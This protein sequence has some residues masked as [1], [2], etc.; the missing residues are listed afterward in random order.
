MVR[1]LLYEAA[2][3]MLT[4]GAQGPS[5]EGRSLEG[6]SLEGLGAARIRKRSGHKKACVALAQAGGDPAA[7]ADHRRAVPLAG[8]EG[9]REGVNERVRRRQRFR[10]ERK[11]GPRRDRGLGDPAYLVARRT[12]VRDCALYLGRPKPKGTIMKRAGKPAGHDFARQPCSR[13][14]TMGSGVLDRETGIRQPRMRPDGT[15]VTLAAPTR[16]STPEPPLQRRLCDLWS[17]PWPVAIH[18]SAIEDW[19]DPKFGPD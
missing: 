13:R 17:V 12:S 3:S 4:G 15:P 6:P 14:R 18:I 2:N 7:H 5:L 1:S 10:T 9:R 16:C 11:P 8:K 19:A